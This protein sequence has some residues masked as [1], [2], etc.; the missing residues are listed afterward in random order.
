M[1]GHHLPPRG[2]RVFWGVPVPGYN[3]ER[4]PGGWEGT[5]RGGH[6]SESLHA[7]PLQGGKPRVL[8]C[9]ACSLVNWPLSK[10]PPKLRVVDLCD[11]WAQ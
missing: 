5:P 8:G 10:S 7:L 11:V 1:Q 4:S 2:P 9:Q 3:S 6:C